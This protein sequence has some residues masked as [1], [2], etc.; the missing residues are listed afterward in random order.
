MNMEFQGKCHT[1]GKY[2]HKQ[3][4]SPKNNKSEKEKEKKFMGKCNHCSKVGH[5][6]VNCWELKAYKDKRPKNW[7]KKEEK[8]VEALSIEVLLGCNKASAIEYKN[9]KVL[10]EID[11]WELALQKLKEILVPINQPNDS[12]NGTSNINMEDN[13]KDD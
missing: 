2:G 1:C 6:A 9:S 8:E 5:K 10:F 13:K 4:K 12:K 11:L 7:K 3:S